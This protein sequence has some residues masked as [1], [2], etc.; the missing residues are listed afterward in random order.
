MFKNKGLFL[1]NL[2]SAI[3]ILQ[4][5]VN[6][7]QDLISAKFLLGTRANELSFLVFEFFSTVDGL[8]FSFNKIV[9]KNFFFNEA[10]AVVVG[11][12]FF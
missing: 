8:N 7:C 6:F 12:K 9:V 4:S 5:L 10:F 11:E 2:Q 3:Y 1:F